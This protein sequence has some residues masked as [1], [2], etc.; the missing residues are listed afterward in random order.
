MNIRGA[1][2]WGMRRAVAT[3]PLR[4]TVA[5][6]DGRDIPA[7]LCVPGRAMIGGDGRSTA[8]GAASIVAKVTR[9]RLM[10]QLARAFPDYGFERHKGYGT[11]EHRETLATFG[12]CV[13]HRRSF[14]PVRACLGVDDAPGAAAADPACADPD[15]T[16]AIGSGPVA[17]HPAPCDAS[18]RKA[19]L[20]NPAPRRGRTRRTASA[21][22]Q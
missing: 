12:P 3:L 9:D 8:I 1:T 20:E 14:A 19:A 18:A 22:M 16:G 4:P 15:V 13:H 6:I 5:L 10:T 7:D 21:A 2:L 11:P 17:E